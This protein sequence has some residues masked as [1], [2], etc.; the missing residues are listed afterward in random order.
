MTDEKNPLTFEDAFSRLENIV[1]ALETGGVS[2]SESLALY[3]DG[4]HLVR[5]CRDFLEGS[6]RRIELISGVDEDGNPI[7]TPMQEDERTLEEKSETRG[8]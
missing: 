4:I 1:T 7:L 6:K 3:E 2:L 5:T 8:R